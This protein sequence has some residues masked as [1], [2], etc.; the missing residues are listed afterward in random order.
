MSKIS[1]SDFSKAIVKELGDRHGAIAIVVVDENSTKTAI[2]GITDLGID[3]N[4]VYM[5]AAL[6]TILEEKLKKAKTIYDLSYKLGNV[7]VESRTENGCFGFAE[8]ATA[9]R[10]GDSKA[11]PESKSSESKK[12]PTENDQFLHNVLLAILD[13]I[14]GGEDDADDD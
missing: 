12:E 11:K 2:S 14:T 10:N 13:E 4:S 7:E 5:A 6:E 8:E 9:P 3:D 1:L